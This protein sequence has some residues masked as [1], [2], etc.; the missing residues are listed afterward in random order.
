MNYDRQVVCFEELPLEW[1]AEAISN[2]DEHAVE[3]SYVLPLKSN[4][5]AIH[6]LIDLTECMRTPHSEFD[7]VIGISNNSGI[8][9]NISP[10]G[11]MCKLTYL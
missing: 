2:L 10:C 8:G 4:R 7:G 11:E 6:A 9:V 5:V 3:A 1:Q